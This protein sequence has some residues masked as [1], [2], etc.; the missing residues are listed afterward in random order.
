MHLCSTFQN[1]IFLS[2]QTELQ[3][4][5][6]DKS[7]GFPGKAYTVDATPHQ[8]VIAGSVTKPKSGM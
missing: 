4:K 8:L 5:S 7:N 1:S 6:F 2:A 3:I